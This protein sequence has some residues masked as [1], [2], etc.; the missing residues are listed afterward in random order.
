M[1]YGR[2]QMKFH[3]VER[4]PFGGSISLFAQKLKSPRNRPKNQ[5]KL[6]LITQKG[7]IC[8]ANIHTFA[9]TSTTPNQHFTRNLYFTLLATK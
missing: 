1:K 6:S 2:K 8:T 5:T 3:K 7:R 4:N 9:P